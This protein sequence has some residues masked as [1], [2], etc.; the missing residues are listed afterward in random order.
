M[1]MYDNSRVG[2]RRETQMLAG[3]L[4]HLLTTGSGS[5]TLGEE[6]CDLLQVTGAAACVQF[7]MLVD[8]QS[9]CT[10]TA[11]AYASSGRHTVHS[12]ICVCRATG[13]MPLEPSAARRTLLVVLQSL[14]PYF[15]QRMAPAAAGSQSWQDSGAWMRRDE[16]QLSPSKHVKGCLPLLPHQ[17]LWQQ[18]SVELLLGGWPRVEASL[19]L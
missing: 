12:A 1:L 16:E 14:V 18:V 15:A 10:V 17:R 7:Q 3:L 5:Q 8:R 19:Y 2:R 4:Y 6:Y 13:S 11:A 9:Y